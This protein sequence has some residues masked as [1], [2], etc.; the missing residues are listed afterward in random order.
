MTGTHGCTDPIWLAA[1]V[2]SFPVLRKY[3]LRALCVGPT[4]NCA[5]IFK[6]FGSMHSLRLR[7]AHCCRSSSARGRPEAFR[8]F[9]ANLTMISQKGVSANASEIKVL[10]PLPEPMPLAY[11]VVSFNE[12]QI[13][14]AL[15]NF[16]TSLVRAAAA[17]DAARTQGTF[18]AT[19]AAAA[20]TR[21][22][23]A[24]HQPFLTGTVTKP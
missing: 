21:W 16:I 1:T 12:P 17:I 4:G 22:P 23:A 11:R 19:S 24:T 10:K 6:T 13:A 9:F 5:W 3:R 2:S 20:V 7:E 8:S 14:A 18:V 15:G